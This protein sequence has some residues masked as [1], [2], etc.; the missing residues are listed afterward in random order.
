MF[1]K[2]DFQ[3]IV[4]QLPARMHRLACYPGVNFHVYPQYAFTPPVESRRYESPE[5]L[6]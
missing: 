5:L 6:K 2:E 4:A 1:G 3:N